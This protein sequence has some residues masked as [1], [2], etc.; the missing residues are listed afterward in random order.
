LL[1]AG[2]W[3]EPLHAL[4]RASIVLVTRK[5]ASAEIASTVLGRLRDAAPAMV[6]A[7]AHLVPDALACASGDPVDR[8]PLD[9]LR[10][11][12][13]LAISAIGDPAAFHR[14][15]TQLG[16]RVT[17]ATY[18]D[19]HAFTGA[20][21]RELAARATAIERVV[22]TLKDAVKLGPLWPRAA[23]ALWYVSQRVD[24]EIGRGE[25]ERLLGS[26]LA[27]RDNLL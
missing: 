27:A 20:E 21:A 5:A 22:C 17:P 23:P 11:A 25:L 16:A 7:V 24:P 6:G 18:S 19:H 9:A 2:P 8:T 10:G 14:Q 15:L 26:V 3:R 12:R 1:P 13:V 4:R